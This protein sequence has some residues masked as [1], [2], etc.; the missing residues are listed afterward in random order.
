[1]QPWTYEIQHKGN[2][3]DCVWHVVRFRES[4]GP[5]QAK[6]IVAKCPTRNLAVEIVH[7]LS[8]VC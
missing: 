6:Y 1:M 3:G 4:S 2:D 5:F 8:T 7:A